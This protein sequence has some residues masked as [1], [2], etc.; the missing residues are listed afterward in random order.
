MASGSSRIIVDDFPLTIQRRSDMRQQLAVFV[1]CLFAATVLAQSVQKASPR[2]GRPDEVLPW[3][4]FRP[5]TEPYKPTDAE[6]A[7][8][9]AKLRQLDEMIGELRSRKVD[10][11]LLADVEIFAEAARWKLEFPQEFFRQ[12]TVSSTQSVLDKGLARATQLKQGQSPWTAQKG[13]VV[14]GFRSAVDGSVQPLRVTIPEEYDPSTSAPLDVALHGRFTSLYEVEYIDT[15]Q[16]AEI[17]Y[18]PGTIQIDV[19]GRGKNAYHWPGETDVFEAMRFVQANYKIDPERMM[20]RGFSMG[21]AG[22]WHIGLHFPDLWASVEVGAGDNESHRMADLTRL[23]PHQQAMCTIFDNMSEWMLNAFNTGFIGYVGEMDGSLRKHILARQQL[24]REGFHFTG[25]SFTD[26]VSVVES[27]GIRYLV[28]PNT[29]H[30]Y[31]PEFRD[32]TEAL[33][34][35]NLKR[36]RQV[37]DHVRFLTYTT[38]YNR[39]FWITIDGLEKHYQRAE[40]DATRSVDR[41]QFEIKSKGLTRLLVRDV[42]AGASINIDA[43]PVNFVGSGEIALEK[44]DGKWKQAASKDDNRLRKRHGRQGPI[45][46]AFLEPFL[47]VRPTGTPWNAAANQQALRLLDEFDQRY[48]IAFRGRMR[49]KNDVQVTEADFAKYHIVLFGDPGSNQWIRR[50]NE[51][52]PIQWTRESVAMGSRR[53]S[54]AEALPALI[55]PSPLSSS[56]YVVINSGITANWEDWAGDFSTAQYGDFAILRV[57]EKNVPDVAY[58]GIFNELWRL[59]ESR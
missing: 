41:K 19:N 20:L 31:P 45:D 7:N 16:G 54:A 8:I 55:Y 28:A 1:L 2:L 27:P 24:L 37:P 44:A 38:R 40:V 6:I 34:R 25:Q 29:P 39:S 30:A 48:R 32:R 14:R 50:L 3:S 57:N 49:I 10:D 15:W 11:Q 53:F 22:V 23:A 26:G 59:P 33:H 4:R 13:R 18:I 52:L 35:E 36:G 46:D 51:K 9:R 12:Q 58:A 5:R 43:E 56:H 21:G 17:R 42:A 47:V